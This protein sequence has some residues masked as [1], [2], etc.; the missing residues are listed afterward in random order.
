MIWATPTLTVTTISSPSSVTGSLPTRA[1][2]RANST[3]A[4]WSGRRQ[5][6][7]NS[8]PARRASTSPG[9]RSVDIRVANC[10]SRSSPAWWPSVSL[11]SLKRSR[12]SISTHAT[13]SGRWLRTASA[14]IDSNSVRPGRP[15]SASW[16]ASNSIRS[17][18]MPLLR[19][20][21]SCSV[22]SCTRA[23]S[24][25]LKWYA[26][27]SRSRIDQQRDRPDL[28][29]DRRHDRL[30][31]D[32]RDIV[33]RSRQLPTSRRA[34][35][36]PSDRNPLHSSGAVAPAAGS[37]NGIGPEACT[38]AVP[39]S[40]NRT[41]A[42]DSARIKLDEVGHGRLGHLGRVERAAR[43]GRRSRALRRGRATAARAGR[44]SAART[45]CRPTG[46]AA[47]AASDRLDQRQRNRHRRQ[48][49]V[50]RVHPPRRSQL[51][52]DAGQRVALEAADRDRDH[53]RRQAAR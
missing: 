53:H 30:R 4:S 21:A 33:G 11:T 50:D 12:S 8:S 13:S 19:L 40:P 16:R 20:V 32:Q 3:D 10:T 15:V 7:A 23:R 9:S 22:R 17:W 2:V 5:R 49:A 51:V 14:A 24:W 38:V 31:R 34:G 46:S 41:S 48:Y 37:L 36:V 1:H 47:N 27:I 28:V 52:A 6:I 29:H 42:T 45:T 26:G 43:R 18:S 35:S 39:S 25:S 44:A